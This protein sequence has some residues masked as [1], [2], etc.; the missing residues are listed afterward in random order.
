MKKIVS[1]LFCALVLSGCEQKQE[2]VIYKSASVERRDIVVAVEAAGIVEPFLT[3]EV[4]SKASGEILN[5]TKDT[6]D[7]L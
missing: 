3:V 2:P 1:I 7:F 5:I 4:K 6:G